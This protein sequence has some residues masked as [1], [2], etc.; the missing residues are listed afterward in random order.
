M[1]TTEKSNLLEII[2][3]ESFS[4]LSWREFA[5]ETF[6]DSLRFDGQTRSKTAVMRELDDLMSAYDAGVLKKMDA[7]HQ[8]GS[9]RHDEWQAMLGGVLAAKRWPPQLTHRIVQ[10]VLRFLDAP[11]PADFRTVN[12]SFHDWPLLHSRINRAQQGNDT[13][14]FF[15]MFEQHSIYSER[16][17][18]RDME[19]VSRP[20]KSKSHAADDSSLP[21]LLG[22]ASLRM[23]DYEEQ[24]HTVPV[25][26]DWQQAPSA[27]KTRIRPYISVSRE[28]CSALH[29]QDELPVVARLRTLQPEPEFDDEFILVGGERFTIFYDEAPFSCGDRF[30]IGTYDCFSID[31][32]L[33]QIEH[34]T[35][36]LMST[37][38]LNRHRFDAHSNDWQHSEL[39]LWLQKDAPIAFSDKELEV[40]GADI[41]LDLPQ[42]AHFFI[43]GYADRTETPSQWSARAHVIWRQSAWYTDHVEHQLK[44]TQ[45]C[46]YWLKDVGAVQECLIINEH[47]A[48]SSANVTSTEIAV[49]PLLRVNAGSRWFV[50]HGSGK[51][52]DPFYID[53]A[54]RL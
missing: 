52:G 15:N 49:R 44:H 6:Y 51:I 54:T 32:T 21:V 36:T 11:I 23:A 25:Y 41:E 50:V 35:L 27:G 7:F 5:R 37:F 22:Y 26:I 24:Q 19:S 13:L 12:Q 1:T 10:A 30:R 14:L 2:R 3:N 45:P 33:V 39:Q 8:R 29:L 9:V 4:P 31:W 42:R 40:L 16:K 20:T 48:L 34:K 43:D 18:Y 28:Q 47:G 17:T 46:S 53:D 38:A